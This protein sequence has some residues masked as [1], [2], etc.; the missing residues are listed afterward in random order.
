MKKYLLW[1]SALLLILAGCSN[2]DEITIKDKNILGYWESTGEKEW[3]TGGLL[4]ASNGEIKHWTYSVHSAD[5]SGPLTYSE[6]HWGYFWFDDDGT[7]NIQ[8]RKKDSD[9]DPDEMY[10]KVTTLTKD[11]LV[12]RSFGGFAGTPLEEGTDI[13]YMKTDKPGDSSDD[14]NI[15]V[16]QKQIVGEWEA[17]HHSKNPQYY[18]TCDMWN[19]TFNADGTGTCPFG[20][21]TFRYEIEGNHITLHLTNIETYYGRITFEYRIVNFSKDRMEWDEIPVD[22][23]DNS[24]YLRFSRK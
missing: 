13:V 5:D 8:N 3:G 9:P 4:F 23:S 14:D 18:D 6:G 7:L 15:D 16:N 12:I 21:K 19:F 22:G 1:M 10:Y 17:S 2:D 24:L 20:T 11:R